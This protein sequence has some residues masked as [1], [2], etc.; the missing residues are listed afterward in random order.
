MSDEAGAGAGA[1]Q[2][3]DGGQ[4][5]GEPQVPEWMGGLSDELKGD[6]I[7]SRYKSLDD[8]AKGHL[9]TKR[10]ASSK[11]IVPGADADQA[12]WDSFYSQIGRPAE[13]SAYEVPSP[14]GT[15]AAYL[16]AFK[17][18]AHALGLNPA[19]AKGLAEWQNEMIGQSIKAGNDASAAELEAFKAATPQFDAKLANAQ[20][21]MKATGVDEAVLTELDVKL[22]TQNL[23]KF[24]FG[25]AERFGEKPRI[26][27]EGREAPIGGDLT[28]AAGQLSRLNADEGFREKIKTGDASAIAMR[29]RLLEAANNQRNAS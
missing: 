16:N 2:Q 22:G 29:K 18:K 4:G 6:A 7:L 3:Q 9:E 20:A 17:G 11:V 12:T 15:D 24:V 21:L 8:F 1:D 5:G 10:V 25:L 19:Q 27:G 14:E 13:A 28:D 26:D 23:L